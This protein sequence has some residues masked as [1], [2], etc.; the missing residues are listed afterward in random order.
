MSEDGAG[1]VSL[2]LQNRLDASNA[3]ETIRQ[4]TRLLR[5][6][7]LSSLVVDLDRVTY[8]DDFGALV[9]IEL[10]RL[11][12]RNG[13]RFELTNVSAKIEETLALVDFDSFSRTTTIKKIR[14][15]HVFTRLGDGTVRV[16]ADL[17]YLISFIGSVCLALLY[18]LFHPRSLRKED[19]LLN[20]QKIGVDALPIVG[21]ISF[22]LGLILAFMSSIQLRQFGADI[23]VASLVSLALVRELG[24]VMTAIIVAGRSGSAFAAEIGTMQVSEEVDALYTMGFEPALFLVVPK[25]LAALIVIPMLTLFADLFGLLGSLVVGVFL[26]NL[27]PNA[28]MEQSIRFLTLTDLYW[29]FFK[30]G[31]FALLITWISCFRGFQVKG[32]AASVGQATTSAVVSSLFLIIMSDSI[33]AVIRVYWG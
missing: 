2:F 9:L 14:P 4:L 24:P 15:P 1:A 20:M 30:S 25:V 33:F 11:T 3:G 13:G 23:Y 6:K 17:K 22:L 5:R 12:L 29:T 18:A 31:V 16:A 19:T 21:M 10:K 7:P 28:Y 26:L 8:L 32:G 27:T